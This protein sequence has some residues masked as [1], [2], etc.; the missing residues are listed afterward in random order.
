[1]AKNSDAVTLLEAT[2]WKNILRAIFVRDKHGSK[3]NW[4]IFAVNYEMF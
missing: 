2:K 3:W 1:M 4:F